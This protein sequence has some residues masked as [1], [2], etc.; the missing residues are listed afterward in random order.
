MNREK[1]RMTK[2]RREGQGG[3]EKDREEGRW[4]EGR[5]EEHREEGRTECRREGQRGKEKDMLK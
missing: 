4:T 1:G 5:R 3:G 2:M